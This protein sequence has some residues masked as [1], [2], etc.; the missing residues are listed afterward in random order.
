MPQFMLLLHEDPAGA[1][2]MSPEEMQ[3][4]VEQYTAWSRRLAAEGRLVRG[5]KLKD[6]GG[7]QV[8]ARGRRPGQ[9]RDEDCRP[10]RPFEP[11]ER[12]LPAANAL[13]RGDLRR[14]EVR[15]GL[16]RDG[17]RPGVART[18]EQDRRLGDD[19][20]RHDGGHWQADGSGHR[21]EHY[22]CGSPS[23]PTSTATGRPSRR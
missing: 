8:R 18:Q 15:S 16:N 1:R 5:V 11:V 2:A 7:R 14:A 3:Q 4:V 21:K 13:S 6:E 9:D 19:D 17:R 22:E 10:D 12:R 20:G 23:P